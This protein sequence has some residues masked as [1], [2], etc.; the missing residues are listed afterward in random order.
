MQPRTRITPLYASRVR[1]LLNQGW[2]PADLA[3][4]LGTTDSVIARWLQRPSVIRSDR[5]AVI[6]T[7]QKRRIDWLLKNPV[8][9]DVIEALRFVV[10]ELDYGGAAHGIALRARLS[11]EPRRKLDRDTIRAWLNNPPTIPRQYW[12]S[13]LR[14]AANSIAHFRAQMD[15]YWKVMTDRGYNFSGETEWPGKDRDD[16]LRLVDEFIAALKAY[17]NGEVEIWDP[18]THRMWDP[19]ELA[20]DKWRKMGLLGSGMAKMFGY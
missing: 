7:N 20:L 9:Q 16:F 14:V 13:I 10:H 4:Q 2:T 11:G 17:V 3:R 8:P 12:S 5:Y 18:Y 15:Y 19:W 1:Q 6:S